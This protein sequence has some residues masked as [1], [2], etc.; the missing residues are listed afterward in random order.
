MADFVIRGGTLVDGTGG[1]QRV[2]VPLMRPA[3]AA[4]CG[5]RF[6]VPM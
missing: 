5:G 4:L 1:E 6:E 3:G 2:A